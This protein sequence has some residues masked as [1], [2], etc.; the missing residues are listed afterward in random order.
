MASGEAAPAAMQTVVLKVS[1]HCHGCKKKVR[2]VLKSIEGVQNVAVD[3]AQHM[4]TVT[5][6]VDADTL[7]K[8]L[9]KSGKQA[10][11]WQ[12]HQPRAAAKKPEA[13]SAPEAQPA[14]AGDGG[15]DSA[16][17][18]ADKKPEEPVKEPQG[19]T[20]EKKPEQE[21]AAPEK[22]PEAEKVTESSKKEEAKPNDEAAKK[23]GGESEAAE[24][25][26]KGA[27]PAKEAAATAAKEVGNDEGEAKKSKSNKPEDAGEAKPVATAE[28][29]LSAPPRAAPKHAFEEYD[30]PYYAPQPVLS[31]HTAQPSASVSYYA[32]QPAYS[33]EH[34]QPQPMQQWSP[35]YLYLPYPH[36]APE[37]YYQDYYS[38]PGTHAAPPPLQDSYRL[39]DDENPNSCSVM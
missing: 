13:A 15:K 24:R 1:I 21:A 25:K 28:R 8:R 19:E 6:T 26:A 30:R 5:G 14:A 32:P 16:A 7:I 17:A 12:W 10:L 27:E 3:A 35:S 33:M 39:F 23:D 38:P 4:V 37:P 11:P 18:A 36:T 31:Y 34:Q 2:K 9:Y 22:K 20:S 29:T